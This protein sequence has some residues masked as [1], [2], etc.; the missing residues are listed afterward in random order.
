MAVFEAA[1]LR[2]RLTWIRKRLSQP[3]ALSPIVA[4]VYLPF[5]LLGPLIIDR[6]RFGG[7]FLQWLVVAL[8]G[9]GALMLVMWVGK[10]QVV[11]LRNREQDRS[12][13]P[14]IIGVLVLAILARA[15]TLAL[16]AFYLQLT[17]D[18]EFDYRLRAGAIAQ[19]AILVLSA[20]LVSATVHHINLTRSL[21][22]QRL[23]LESVAQQ[24]I[25]RLEGIR[26]ST[27]CEVDKSVIPLIEKLSNIVDHDRIEPDYQEVQ[28][29]ATRIIDNELRPLSQ[30]VVSDAAVEVNL[31]QKSDQN[32]YGKI[33]FP[34]RIGI[35][36]LI[37][38]ILVAV[39]VGVL[40]SSQAVR[41]QS[42]PLI[43]LLP[44]LTMFLIASILYIIRWTLRNWVLSTWVAIP[45]AVILIVL[46]IG[47]VYWINTN[48][49]NGFAGPIGLA[50]LIVFP[51]VSIVT[52]FFGLTETTVLEDEQQLSEL[53]A[54]LLVAISNLR[55]QEFIARKNLSYV[56]H[57]AIQG[58]LHASSMRLAAS[59][60]PSLELV[61]SIRQ[62]L[63][64]VSGKIDD[65]AAN[66]TYLVETLAEIAE[67]WEGT[68]EV[69][70]TLDYRTVSI[71]A[72][73]P[74]AAMSV[75]EIARETVVNAVR[76]GG[77]TEV[78]IEIKAQEGSVF[79][80]VVDNGAGVR[81]S[82]KGGIGSHM[83]NDLCLNWNRESS[84]TGTRIEA[85][86]PS[87][88]AF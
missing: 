74:T 7:S 18:L 82:A 45:V 39:L 40:A 26:D 30:R 62:D 65:S 63:M 28:S 5:G 68:C 17:P 72:G 14:A 78:S 27:K 29:I 66:Y 88:R 1:P 55:Q 42:F 10:T 56:I 21:E 70:W 4:L 25:Q 31:S 13:A 79:I 19:L 34:A 22:T 69:K 61:E 51:V 43:V 44:A 57:G 54:Q 3:A 35:A 50:A 47:L 48:I 76:H 58:A 46:C 59:D 86:L 85:Q 2:R 41:D 15:L 84:E 6:N 9:Q 8:L 80:T 38:P 37:R 77:A 32:K 24:M 20:I 73:S 12:S 60:R 16:V 49:E 83:M 81:E 53:N 33:T 23:D 87:F 36:F 75:A 71:I 64:N 11:R 52:V 67:L